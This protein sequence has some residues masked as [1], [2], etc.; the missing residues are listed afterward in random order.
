MTTKHH[1]SV[2]IDKVLLN[3]NGNAGEAAN[4]VGD[5]LNYSVTIKNTGDVML[6]GVSVV[7]PLTGQ[8]IS[9]VTLAVGQTKVY[10]SSY[11]ITQADLNGAGNAGSDH[12]IDNTA[13][14]DSDQT[15]CV[16]DSTHTP[17]TFDPKLAVEKQFVNV[18]GNAGEVAN[19]VGDVLHYTVTVTNTGN[20]T[21]TGVSVVDPLTGQN[22]SGV[23]LA[24][25]ASQ[26][27]N[28]T[29]T[30]TQADLDGAGNAGADHDIDNVAT[31][32]SNQTAP[33]YSN[34]VEVP[35]VSQHPALTID[36]ELVNVNGQVG[37]E[38]NSVGDVLNYS[39]TIKNTGDVALTGVT[40]VDPLTGQNIVGVALAVGETK[41]YTS[42]YAITQ[43][44]LDGAGNA[45]SDHDIDNTA[46]VD[47]GQTDPV[48]DSVHTPLVYNPS[49]ETEKHFLDVNGNASEQANS[50]GDVI[51][52]SVSIHN[53]G[54]VTLTG[55]SVVDPL[56]GQN[57]SGVTLAPGATQT[58]NTSYTVT[59][60]DLAGA[61]N[62]GPDLDIDNTATADSAQTPP[63][64]SNTVEV[65]LFPVAVEAFD[66][67]PRPTYS[68]DHKSD[69]IWQDFAGG[70]GDPLMLM[71]NGETAAP[72]VQFSPW[73]TGE[74]PLWKIQ[75]V[76]DFNG[77]GDSEIVW[78]HDSNN[79]ASMWIMDETDVL[80]V[81]Q[82]GSGGTLPVGAPPVFPYGPLGFDIKAIG[83]VNGDGKDDVISQQVNG[84]VV[85]WQ[86]DGTYDGT[87]VH[88]TVGPFA[89]GALA[90]WTVK[91]SGD[92]NGDG[93]ADLVWQSTSG[94][95][96]MWL[97]DASFEPTFVGAVGPFNPGADWQIKGVGDLNGDGMDDLIFQHTGGQVAAWMMDGTD[98]TFV[99]AIGPF[100][101]GA[102]WQVQ[103][104]GDFNND[105]K[106][107]ILFKSVGTGLVAE[108]HMDGTETTFVGAVGTSLPGSGPLFTGSFNT[109]D[110]LDWSVY[111]K[112][113]S[114]EAVFGVD[115]H[116]N[117]DGDQLLAVLNQPAQSN[118]SPMNL[119][120]P[121][122]KQ[123]VTAL[124]NAT[125]DAD[126]LVTQQYRFSVDDVIAAVKE[127]YDDG[128]F[129]TEQ[130]G[131]LA[132]LLTFWNAAPSAN[133]GPGATVAGE[134]HSNDTTPIATSLS[135]NGDLGGSF[136]G[137]I[138]QVLA[139]LHPDH[140][141]LV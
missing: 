100:N 120:V 23:T 122:A 50:A 96:A 89:S 55:V 5:V 29:Y 136:D 123:A 130:G 88:D 110:E 65:P 57:V 60:A 135:F 77:D 54:N 81:G 79:L 138:F 3:V 107:D 140:G 95:V 106:S 8:N 45:G 63:A 12:D 36:K 47:S 133:I 58:F 62:A 141:W 26:S 9:G 105:G 70:K 85:I 137:N 44:D 83:D 92:F 72:L 38:A 125:N 75:G 128:G 91:G 15:S 101:P 30:I 22:V 64:T 17:L 94:Q 35:I 14:V 109:G 24:P 20:V 124:L 34:N 82:L 49:L 113:D 131:D 68:H 80:H 7:D 119:E 98:T 6:T 42:S 127:V 111:S 104:T 90:G 41:V 117:L 28:T 103:G 118:A 16:T 115:A 87:I 56:T 139:T 10:T 69:I 32:D 59:A 46:T 4:S 11:A 52:Y 61:G 84:D 126:G 1:P 114:Y 116:G 13:T 93:N 97:M 51:H 53:T 19:S 74:L 78:Q 21:L 33:K 108:W 121:L 37:E 134:L 48:T 71:G 76:G 25:G 132:R 129:N 67:E 86:M 18:N 31:A 112:T 39:V 2:S 27:F 43:A 40:V 102:D 99:G 66:G 73:P